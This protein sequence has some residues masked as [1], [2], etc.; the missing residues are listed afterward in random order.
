MS[1]SKYKIVP[2][3]WINGCQGCPNYYETHRMRMCRHSAIQS[4][5]IPGCSFPEWCPLEDAE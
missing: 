4:R 2:T 3:F 5:V 1:D